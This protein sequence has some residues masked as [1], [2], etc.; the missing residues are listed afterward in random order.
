MEHLNHRYGAIQ[1]VLR[2]Y[3][4]ADTERLKAICPEEDSGL[5]HGFY[6]AAQFAEDRDSGVVAFQ[7]ELDER[8]AKN[9]HT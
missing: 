5:A 4:V 6:N 8:Y 9:L 1:F 3:G 7:A 2:H